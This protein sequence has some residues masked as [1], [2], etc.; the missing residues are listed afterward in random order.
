MIDGGKCA[1][2]W[3]S[4]V[5]EKDSRGPSGKGSRPVSYCSLVVGADFVL[6]GERN[7]EGP[8]FQG[9]MCDVVDAC[10]KRGTA[11]A[12]QVLLLTLDTVEQRVSRKFPD[13]MLWGIGE[14]TGWEHTRLGAL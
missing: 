7:A 4:R 13:S 9:I 5:R 1:R 3:G 11:A 14:G 10:R 12:R 6:D 2:R 8:R